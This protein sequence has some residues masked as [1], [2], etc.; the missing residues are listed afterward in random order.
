MSGSRAGRVGW[1]VGGGGFSD[2]RGGGSGFRGR[3]A[4]ARGAES[5]E[6]RGSK[7]E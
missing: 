5:A 6:R 4:K 3:P 1:L 2:E 7:T